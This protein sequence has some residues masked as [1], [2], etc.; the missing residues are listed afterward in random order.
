MAN[1]LALDT[2]QGHFQLVHTCNTDRDNGECMACSVRDCPYDE[3]LHWHHDGCPSC[4]HR[5]DQVNTHKTNTWQTFI[6]YTFLAF[7]V[8]AVTDCM[9]VW[10]L[11]DTETV[12][13]TTEGVG[14]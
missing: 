2:V 1:F 3:P 5:S 7:A 8:F 6:I 9:K 10:L 13:A 12:E 4:D 14:E 11:G